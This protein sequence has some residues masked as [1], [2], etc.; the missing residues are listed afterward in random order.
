MTA[1]P[2]IGV[3]V[4]DRGAKL[5]WLAHWLAVRRAGGRPVR[6]SA[7]GRTD[8]MGLD[9]VVI[10]GGDDIGAEM[11]GGEVTL[12]LRIDP[13]RDRME[14]RALDW[15]LHADVPV[16]GVCRGAQMINIHLGGTLH[17]DMYAAYRGLPRLRTP[18][19]RK[20]I[21]LAPESRLAR[22]M[23][24]G[25]VAVNSLHHQAVNRLGRGLRV[26]ARDAHRVVQA[27]E[28]P[29]AGFLMGVQWHPEFLVFRRRHQ[30]LYRGLVR[31]ARE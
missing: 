11:Y 19:A 7:G 12:D 2:R 29:A 20:R 1:R 28:D 9:G 17:Q 10:G 21:T 15:A 25:R 6:L 18:L 5:T 13:D 26:A 24:G 23:G 16:L 22:L 30:A 31:A 27:L 3:T 8:T 4:S 14:R